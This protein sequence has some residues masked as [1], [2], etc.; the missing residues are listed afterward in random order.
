MQETTV[1]LAETEPAVIITVLSVAWVIYGLENI[2]GADFIAPGSKGETIVPLV[3]SL[4]VS[5]LQIGVYLKLA[6]ISKRSAKSLI[7][8]FSLFLVP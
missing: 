4:I 5:C 7:Y 3:Q 2:G 6:S 1:E 8:F